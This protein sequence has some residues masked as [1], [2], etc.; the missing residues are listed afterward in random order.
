MRPGLGRLSERQ[1]L[2]GRSEMRPCASS[3]LPRSGT[4]LGVSLMEVLVT[5][6]IIGIL[7]LV[8]VPSYN[9]MIEGQRLR[10]AA[11]A[12]ASDLRWARSEAIK[13][14]A[15]VRVG[16]TTGSSW[17]YAV[18]ADAN[19]NGNFDDDVPVK[20]ISSADFPSV[21]LDSVAFGG[22]AQTVFEP[23][24]ATATA[25]TAFLSTAMSSARVSLSAAGGIGICGLR[26][27]EPC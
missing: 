14:S 27:Y 1:R 2:A 11:E 22:D 9:G 20:V 8:A 3:S 17:A 21:R 4:A 18:T 16:F 19:R 5:I 24:R 25:G 6:A 12:L 26:G 13:R 15:Q 7:A 10:G 23:V